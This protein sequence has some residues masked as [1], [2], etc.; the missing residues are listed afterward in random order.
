MVQGTNIAKEAGERC[1][2]GCALPVRAGEEKA[3]WG[4]DVQA[5]GGKGD[6]PLDYLVRWNDAL[7]QLVKCDNSTKVRDVRDS[8][9]GQGVL[10]D[11]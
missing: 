7:Y 6:A 4:D 10:D 5:R 9:T 11:G 8:D 2:G 3:G 1:E